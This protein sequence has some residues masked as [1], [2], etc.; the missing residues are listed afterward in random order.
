M[1]KLGIDID[2]TITNTNSY[3]IECAKEYDKLIGNKGFQDEDAYDFTEMFYWTLDDKKGF[4]NY[5]KENEKL[6]N[7]SLRKDF[8]EVYDELIKMVK[9]YFI[10]SR[11]EKSYKIPYNQTKKWLEDNHIN[12][13]KL[14]VGIKEKG[15]ICKEN[16]IDLFIDDFIN[17]CEDAKKYGINAILMTT[18]YNKSSDLKRFDNWHQIL[19]YIRKCENE[20]NK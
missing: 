5:V 7:V 16:K 20:K 12:Y 3:L 11:S 6:M 19:E 10:S 18:D 15:I 9:I 4:F 8:R 1:I 13:E 17:Q 2:D 14:Y